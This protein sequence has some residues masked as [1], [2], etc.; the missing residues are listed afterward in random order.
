M[1]YH[2][3]SLLLGHVVVAS[4]NGN[5]TCLTTLQLKPELRIG[6]GGEYEPGSETD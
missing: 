3:L 6:L 1:H 2:L 5:N 4:S